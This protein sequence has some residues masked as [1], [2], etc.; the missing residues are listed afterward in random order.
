GEDDFGRFT[1]P[2]EQ[3]EAFNAAQTPLQRIGVLQ[4]N[5]QLRRQ[6]LSQTSF[7]SFVR[8]TMIELLKGSPE[9]MNAINAASKGIDAPSPASAVRFAEIVEN[10]NSGDLATTA[11]AARDLAVAEERAKLENIMGQRK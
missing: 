1:V 9:V 4:Q 2:K 7:D 6:F 11:Q 3:I 8:S 10:L 5:E